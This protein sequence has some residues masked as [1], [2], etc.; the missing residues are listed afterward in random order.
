[1]KPIKEEYKGSKIVAWQF[2]KKHIVCHL[3]RKGSNNQP[4]N[5][6]ECHDGKRF[7]SVRHA[8]NQAKDLINYYERKS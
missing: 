3:Y 6:G 2:D 1:M 4:L 5:L 7:Q 8:V